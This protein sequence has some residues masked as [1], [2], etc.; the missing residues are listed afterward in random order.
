MSDYDLVVIGGG[1]TGLAAAR[2]ARQAGRRVALIERARPGG[3]CTH[4]G[5]VPSKTLI[6]S[7]RRVAAARAGARYGFTAS[8][9]VDFPA[10]MRRVQRVIADIE[11]D[12]SPRLLAWQGIDLVGG[13]ARFRGPEAIEVA[14]RT[15]TAQRFVVATGG[16]PIAPP[17]AGLAETGYL[18]NT[19]VFS[20][21]QQPSHLVVLG[22]GPIGVELAQAFCRL[23]SA[24]SVVE[25]AD[26][27]LGRDEP[28][29]A[30]VV[31]AVLAREGVDVRTGV[32]AARVEPGPTVVLA[33]G[34]RIAGSD[35]LVA[36]GRAPVTEGLDLAAAGVALDDR[37]GVRVDAYLRTTNPVIFAAGD[38]ASP[39]QFTHVGDDQ[40]RL[41]AGN[42]FA[43]RGRP[44][45][46][47]GLR[48]F[49]D[50]VVPRVTYTDPEVASVGLTES[51][52]Y[53]RYGEHAR[54]AAVP[55][56]GMDRPRCA[57]ETDGFVKLVAAPAV[58]RL[59]TALALRLVGMTVVAGPAG[60]MLGEGLIA[61]QART[62]VAR[63]AQAEHAYPTWSIATRLAAAQ[64]FGTFGGRTARAARPG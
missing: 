14:G 19:T 53:Q 63:L 61:M 64:F 1:A 60:E 5:C 62:L 48:R 28:E 23:G 44:G 13:E 20:L 56:S 9:D 38:C 4:Y 54:V 47:G 15:I 59:P 32:A 22:G 17:V 10:V 25:A 12:E 49:D 39:L 18:D 50:R 30:R 6:E 42:A 2:A 37:G 26:R 11:G 29:A 7:A 55:M 24:V 43:R 51:A 57:G 3:D 33:D 31:A 58:G 52:A 35:L 16:R 46:L 27:L 8:I 41:A 36:V 21:T 40:G 34:A 45:L